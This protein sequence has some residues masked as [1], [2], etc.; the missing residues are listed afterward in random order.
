MKNEESLR[1]PR[2]VGTPHSA[3]CPPP[4]VLI[5][6]FFILPSP[7][8]SSFFILPSSFSLSFQAFAEPLLD[9]ALV[10]QVAGSRQPLDLPQHARVNAQWNED[11][12]REGRRQNEE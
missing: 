4:S 8:S 6:S 1:C 11:R 7:F 12:R 2:R 5:S 10:I 3:F 9:H